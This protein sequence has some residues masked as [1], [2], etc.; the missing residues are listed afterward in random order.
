MAKTWYLRQI[1]ADRTVPE[2][3][4]Q[5]GD[6]SP[7]CPGSGFICALFGTITEGGIDLEEEDLINQITITLSSGIDQTRV[8]L[9]SVN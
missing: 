7:P 8:L 6:T 5:Y 4:I 1:G 9:R 2:S 3:Y